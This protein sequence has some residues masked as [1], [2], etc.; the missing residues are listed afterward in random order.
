MDRT[1]PDSEQS[2]CDIL[3]DLETRE[4]KP[5]KPEPKATSKRQYAIQ[6]TADMLKVPFK[7]VLWKT[8]VWPTDM[9]LDFYTYCMKNGNPPAKLWWGLIKKQNEKGTKD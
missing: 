3:K 7:T 4:R 5:D 8:I 1:G 6:L 2:D 9:I